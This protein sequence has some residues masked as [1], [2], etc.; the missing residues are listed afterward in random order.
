MIY[1]NLLLVLALSAPVF[2]VALA[3]DQNSDNSDHGRNNVL[4][5]NP[6]AVQTGSESDGLH[7]SGFETGES[8]SATYV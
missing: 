5:L 8:P 1:H 2:D 6:S 3:I 4:E 7:A